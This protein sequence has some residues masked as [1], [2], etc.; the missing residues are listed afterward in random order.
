MKRI[1]SIV[2]PIGM[3]SL[4]E[5][6][7]VFVSER[8]FRNKGKVLIN[9]MSTEK[10]EESFRYFTSDAILDEQ[11][12]P[13]SQL[14]V[15]ISPITK[16]YEKNRM[17]RSTIVKQR[18]YL[19]ISTII[20]TLWGVF[21]CILT[22]F[23]GIISSVV[24]HFG[25]WSAFLILN[26]F[27]NVLSIITDKSMEDI[28]RFKRMFNFT[29]FVN[30]IGFLIAAVSTNYRLSTVCFSTLDSRCENIL[31]KYLQC[32]FILTFILTTIHNIL[33]ILMIYT[34]ENGR[35]S[36]PIPIIV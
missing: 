12:P 27:I 20:Y 16:Y 24:P 17:V 23:C 6:E 26:G 11:P 36:R 32:I 7:S 29:L 15:S 22:V 1:W 4:V 8:C 3:F 5:L 30:T 9:P 18:N 35:K 19:L 31:T 10:L 28:G 14:T 13:Y 33:N 25:L 21:A 2:M 34:I